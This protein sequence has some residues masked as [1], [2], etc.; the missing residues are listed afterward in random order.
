MRRFKVLFGSQIALCYTPLSPGLSTSTFS[1]KIFQEY[2]TL[3]SVKQIGSR[4]SCA[5]P[6]IFVRGDQARRSES[7]LDNVRFFV[8]FQSSIL[9]YSLQIYLYIYLSTLAAISILFSITFSRAIAGNISQIKIFLIH[10][11]QLVLCMECQFRNKKDMSPRS[12][13]IL[14]HGSLSAFYKFSDPP[15][16]PPPHTHTFCHLNNSYYL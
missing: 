16:P 8:V 10:C 9:F 12:I 4:S 5:D 3:R 11:I 1:I 13:L 2:S 6:G 14:S 7:S 15:P